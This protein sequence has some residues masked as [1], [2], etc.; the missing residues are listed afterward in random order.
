[1]TYVRSSGISDGNKYTYSGVQGKC[2]RS[3]NPALRNISNH[4]FKYLGGDENGLKELVSKGPVAVGVGL[5]VDMMYYKSGVF[6]DPTCMA[7][8]D[9]AVVRHF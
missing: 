9:H 3:L 6:Y 5:T 7:N 2:L 1:M 4:C 8:T